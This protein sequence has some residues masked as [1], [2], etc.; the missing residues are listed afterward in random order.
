MFRILVT[1]LLLAS[2]AYAGEIPNPKP[3]ED[4]SVSDYLKK[5]KD[6]WLNQIIVTT[7]PNG[8]R[9]GRLGDIVVYNNAGAYTWFM[10]TTV[11]PNFGTTWTQ[12]GGSGG[13]VTT[14]GGDNTEIQFN[15]AGSFGG[16]DSA[17]Y[18]STTGHS[19]FG[20]GATLNE[21][22]A[23]SIDSH[24]PTFGSEIV[25]IAETFTTTSTSPV[26]VYIQHISNHSSATSGKF[27]TALYVD[28]RN[29]ATAATNYRDTAINA[30]VRNENTSATVD[31]QIG[32]RV[33][34]TNS[35]S[36]TTTRSYGMLV[37]FGDAEP[38]TDSKE[39]AGIYVS[40]LGETEGD[41]G[42]FGGRRG[43][44]I[45]AIMNDA[46]QEQT[47]ND[48]LFN[49]YSAG[50]RD[51]DQVYKEA[52]NGFAGPS[53]F[54]GT[55]KATKGVVRATYL[56]ATGTGTLS[57]SG[58]AVTGTSTLF[59]G[60]ATGFGHGNPE[61][62]DVIVASSQARLFTSGASA[63][64]GTVD[65]A[66][67]SNL[68]GA[69]FTF[70]KPIY[71]WDVLQESHD[72]K[73]GTDWIGGVINA[74]GHVGIGT[75][76]PTATLEI[77]QYWKNSDEASIEFPAFKVANTDINLYEA[78]AL[79][80]W[81]SSQF[82]APQFRGESGGATE[83]VTNASTVYI[84]GNPTADSNATV[85]NGHALWVDSGRFR[86]DGEMVFYSEDPQLIFGTT[87]VILASGS[88]VTLEATGNYTLTSTPTIASAL[89]TGQVLY[90]AGRS[91]ETSVVTLQ[92]QDSLPNSNLQ[93]G[94]ATRA[95]GANDV[96][97]LL[98][99]GVDWLEVSYANN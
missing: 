9:F 56:S 60:N 59:G 41:G 23:D 43:I 39:R 77:G 21:S 26:G 8:V 33:V 98:F 95:I 14:P 12:V 57:S 53:N 17:L 4:K 13:G 38:S 48:T 99:N 40:G 63:T 83:T 90:I 88:M 29:T 97:K 5:I 45:D 64:A 78:S 55:E 25:N 66:W 22:Y 49:L 6:N 75:M 80:N 18:D 32:M 65:R 96:L 62:G 87:A 28:K 36:T 86:M 81:R 46:D 72:H 82:L 89:V 19:A 1:L 50:S 31:E 10:N 35:G 93:L 51:N 20:P 30:R 85:T 52:Y 34:A 54:G 61:T 3:I 68:S 70:S 92:D 37:K 94:A 15:N 47:L 58:T 16:A 67:P 27:P 69:S 79:T 7:S 42:L 71:R 24:S 91:D 84:D 73:Q 11:G 76:T 2:A 44:Y 74:L